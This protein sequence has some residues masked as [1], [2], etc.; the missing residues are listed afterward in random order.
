MTAERLLVLTPDPAALTDPSIFSRPFVLTWRDTENLSSDCFACEVLTVTELPNILSAIGLAG[1]AGPPG[2]VVRS[3]P[4]GRQSYKH[5]T[6]T[7]YIY[8]MLPGPLPRQPGSWIGALPVGLNVIS[9]FKGSS[10]PEEMVH[11]PL[12]EWKPPDLG[13]ISL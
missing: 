1:V 4:P 2:F 6:H 8:G 12:I 9:Y 10:A 3:G 13:A 7:L 11:L 5:D